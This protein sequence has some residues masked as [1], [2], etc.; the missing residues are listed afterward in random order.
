[1]KRSLEDLDEIERIAD[2][3]EEK[4]ELGVF[5]KCER[6]EFVKTLHNIIERV[7]KKNH[8]V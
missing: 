6:S 2:P 5:V 3:L 4:I 8:G 7:G 1:M